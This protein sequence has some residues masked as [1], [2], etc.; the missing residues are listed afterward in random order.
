MA[1]L[2]VLAVALALFAGFFALTA[3]EARRGA[4]LF[5]EERSRLDRRVE[6]ISFII[7]HVDWSAFAKEE[8]H[9]VIGRLTHDIAHAF[10]RAV[11]ATERFL[12][13]LVR[14]LRVR[15]SIEPAPRENARE[16]VKHLSD[17]KGRLSAVR[18]EVPDVLS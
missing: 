13:N 3:F 2:I 16:F 18:P 12:T 9:R 4:R 1:Y 7:A 17:F 10:L 11:R 8:A 6:R 5:S 14:H 15:H